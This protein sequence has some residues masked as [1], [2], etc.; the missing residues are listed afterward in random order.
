MGDYM[1]IDQIDQKVSSYNLFNA[2]V[3]VFELT[4]ESDQT[5]A[6]NESYPAVLMLVSVACTLTF[7]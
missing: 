1:Y 7:F 3:L 6:S 2:H 4:L 5:V